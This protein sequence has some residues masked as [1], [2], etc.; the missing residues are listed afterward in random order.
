MGNR[1][2]LRILYLYQYLGQNTTSEQPRS[3]AELIKML[4][5]KNGIDVGVTQ[6]AMI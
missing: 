3:T 5:G 2:K 4:S 6:F 1:S